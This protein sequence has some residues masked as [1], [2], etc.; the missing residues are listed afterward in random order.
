MIPPSTEGTNGS[1]LLYTYLEGLLRCG[2]VDPL[3]LIEMATP[4]L[5]TGDTDP[6]EV[7]TTMQSEIDGMFD[8][9]EGESPPQQVE[10]VPSGGPCGS[11]GGSLVGS[12]PEDMEEVEVMPASP[13]QE[14]ESKGGSTGG[15]GG[16]GDVEGDGDVEDEV[17]PASPSQEQGSKGDSDEGE[18]ERDGSPMHTDSDEG[19][20]NGEVVQPKKS[21]KGGRKIV[22]DDES[23]L[24]ELLP[25]KRKA[26]A[27]P[28][29]VREGQ[30]STICYY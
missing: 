24:P 9:D 2:T 5:Q 23:D 20:E 29:A 4:Y 8:G 1:A 25:P 26:N 19:S 10:D 27:K 12:A 22:S 6:M 11:G 15:G 14:Q 13:S 7:D 17:M 16:H 3:K 18:G 21:P 28:P 30:L